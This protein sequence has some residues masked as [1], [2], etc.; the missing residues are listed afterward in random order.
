MSADKDTE[1]VIKIKAYNNDRGIFTIKS[2]NQKLETEH[3]NDMTQFQTT[4]KFE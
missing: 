4:T 3:D 1:Y 2:Q